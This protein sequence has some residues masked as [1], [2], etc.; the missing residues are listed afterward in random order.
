MTFKNKKIKRIDCKYRWFTTELISRPVCGLD[1]PAVYD[2]ICS[3]DIHE[4]C[5]YHSERKLKQN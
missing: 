4:T 5:D 1:E 2:S 3:H